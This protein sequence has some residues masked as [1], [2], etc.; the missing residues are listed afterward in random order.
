VALSPAVISKLPLGLLGFFGIKNGGQ[1]PQTVG[2]VIVPQLDMGELLAANY[3]ERLGL[4][5][6]VTATG[7]TQ[8]T[9]VATGGNAIVPASELWYVMHASMV[10]STLAGDAV[11]Y[12]PVVRNTQSGSASASTRALG[13][14]QTQG[15]G[16][17]TV[18]PL[19]FENGSRWFVPG[20]S[21]GIWTTS[22]TLVTGINLSMQLGITR[23]P[24]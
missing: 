3:H 11:V 14:Q 20:D 12:T 13:A 6:L 15:A 18:H 1:Y 2:Q 8:S 22:F 17:L 21:F 19:T 23:F 24:F 10:A 4:Q 5:S 16:L 7:F 9:I